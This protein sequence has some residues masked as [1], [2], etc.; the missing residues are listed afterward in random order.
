VNGDTLHGPWA[1][2]S[3]LLLACLLALQGCASPSG[4]VATAPSLPPPAR[5][6]AAPRLTGLA[7]ERQWLQSW[8]QGTPVRVEAIGPSGFG[9][10]IP[11]EFS[12]DP[13][14]SVVKPPLGA[15]LDKLAQSLQ[16]KPAARV[17]L[18]AAPGDDAA[19]S[20]LALQRAGNV[21]KYLLARGVLLQQV[22]PPTVAPVA[23]VQLRVGMAEH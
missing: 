5:D 16:R 23:A 9:V 3:G 15:V 8:F 14:R 4:A 21:R 19:G 7:A 17:E 18:L 11:R 6:T 2:W 13:G 1:A 20:S 12:F 22:G 10:E